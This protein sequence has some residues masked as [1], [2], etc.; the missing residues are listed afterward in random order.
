MAIP[1]TALAGIKW[2]SSYHFESNYI[3]TLINKQSSTYVKKEYTKY[4][5]HPCMMSKHTRSKSQNFGKFETPKQDDT[6][7]R[8]SL[9][10]VTTSSVRRQNDDILYAQLESEARNQLKFYGIHLEREGI[11]KSV[12]RGGKYIASIG[13]DSTPSRRSSTAQ[14]LGSPKKVNDKNLVSVEWKCGC[15]KKVRPLPTGR[16]D[17]FKEARLRLRL[18]LLE[19][20]HSHKCQGYTPDDKPE[21]IE[22]LRAEIEAITGKPQR[23]R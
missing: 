6:Y 14:I 17:N 4:I 12:F 1:A 19:D 21:E 10:E 20:V 5:C 23:R 16:G 15:S 18:A 11:V 13:E 3:A 7:G 2:Y 9:P 22:A 8:S